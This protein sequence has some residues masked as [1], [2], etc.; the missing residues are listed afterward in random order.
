MADA[1]TLIGVDRPDDGIARLTLRRADKRNALSIALRDEIS[2]TLDSLSSDDTLKVVV[3]TGE[4]NTFCAGFD[5]GEFEV[6]M[7]DPDYADRLWASSDRYH[8]AIA[9]F[10]LP[11]VAAVNGPALGGGFDL[12]VLCDLRIAA[13][14]ARLA[15]PE[16]VFGDVVYT[17]LADLVGGAWARELCMTGRSLDAEEAHAIHLVNRVVPATEL[18][19]AAVELARTIALAPRSNLIRTKAKALAR[20]ALPQGGTLDL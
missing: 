7:S 1:P 15:H 9:T 4:G 14:T 10:P 12:A 16:Y 17:P 8:R 6:A 11:T 20:G 19:S 2:D 3:V 18:Q 13:D 5:L